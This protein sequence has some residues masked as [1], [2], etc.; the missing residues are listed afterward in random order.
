L[1]YQQ[2]QGALIEATPALE[3]L[4]TQSDVDPDLPLSMVIPPYSAQYLRF[5]EHAAQA[6]PS[7]TGNAEQ[8]IDGVFCFSSPLVLADGTPTGE[9]E[10]S[11]AFVLKTKNVFSGCLT[12]STPI[13]DEKFSIS[14]WLDYMLTQADSYGQGHKD[15]D[16]AMQAISYVA[17]VFLYLSLKEARQ[18]AVNERS[19]PTIG[20]PK[21]GKRR[22]AFLY[23]RIVVG[24]ESLPQ[25]NT[26]DSSGNAVSP[27][28]RRGHFR[29]QTHG[30]QGSLRKVMFIMPTIVRADRLEGDTPAPK[31]YR[32]R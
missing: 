8:Q 16:K 11:L 5:G 21:L 13:K 9:H 30:P 15:H 28:W 4:L 3:V 20:Q 31:N 22:Q 25:L 1:A 27:H 14:T 2:R 6:L 32:A 19:Q 10:F 24:P 26:T 29:M 7:P 17:K 18:V 23:D 12:F